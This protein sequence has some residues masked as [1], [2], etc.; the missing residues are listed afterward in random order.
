[1]YQ[2]AGAF[3][4]KLFLCTEAPQHAAAFHMSVLRCLNI[5]IAV[6]HIQHLPGLH[7]ELSHQAVQQCR[8]RLCGGAQHMAGHCVEQAGKIVGRHLL[9]KRVFLIG[10]HT[11]PQPGAL[12]RLQHGQNA[13]V[14]GGGVLF[15]GLI[16]AQKNRQRR[17]LRGGA[18]VLF[19]Q[20]ALNKFGNAVA[21]Q[22]AVGVYR[23]RGKT[24]H[25]QRVVS[26][27]RKVCQG[28]QQC[29]VQIE[30]HSGIH[31]RKLLFAQNYCGQPSAS[32]RALR[33]PRTRKVWC[34]GSRTN[35]LLRPALTEN[36]FCRTAKLRSGVKMHTSYLV[37]K[38]V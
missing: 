21:H 25:F 22:I 1:M 14:G 7:A 16:I 20:H 10:H 6:A 24:Q 9:R 5:H 28:V 3:C 32:A 13:G 26:G 30:Y 17:L 34:A 19:R 2:I 18:A 8:V 12:Q 23:V 31:Q 38:R 33:T 37:K 4:P 15:V 27:V 36:G 35:T 29:A 11:K